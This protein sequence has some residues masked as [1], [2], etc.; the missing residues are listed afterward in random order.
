ME[1]R[2]MEGPMQPIRVETDGEQRRL[3]LEGVVNAALARRLKEEALAALAGTGPVTLDLARAEYL[4]GAALQILLALG[5]DLAAR[6]RGFRVVAMP[7]SVED[8]LRVVGLAGTL[9]ADPPAAI[10]AG[11]GTLS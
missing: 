11:R 6:G 1:T 3:C 4:D 9:G 5:A 2:S 7:P 10:G 8:T